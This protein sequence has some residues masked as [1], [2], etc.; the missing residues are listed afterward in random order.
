MTMWTNK[1][2]ETNRRQLGPLGATEKFQC[3][4][5]YAPPSLSAAVAHLNRSAA[6]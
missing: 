3:A 6:A 4:G 1:S 2:M 5:A